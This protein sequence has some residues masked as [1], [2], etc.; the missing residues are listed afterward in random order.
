MIERLEL[1][2]LSVGDRIAGMACVRAK[3]ERETRTGDAYLT[4]ELANSSGAISAKVWRDAHG[5]PTA[6]AGDP[7]S[8]ADIIHHQQSPRGV[9]ELPRAARIGRDRRQ[10]KFRGHRGENFQEAQPYG[11]G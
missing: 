11:I 9:A 3:V 7:Q 4:V 8:G 1:E 5:R 2:T 6:I 10:R